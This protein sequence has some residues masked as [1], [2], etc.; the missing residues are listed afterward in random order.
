MAPG[1]DLRIGDA[2]RDVTTRQLRECFAQGRLT[3]DEFNDR[4]GKAL[5]ATTQPELDRLTRDLP[6]VMSSPAPLPHTA[7]YRGDPRYAYD[8]RRDHG[9]WQGQDAS[10][11][12]GT[13][14]RSRLGMGLAVLFALWLL[15]SVLTPLALFPFGGRIALLLLVFGVLRGIVRRLFGVR[16]RR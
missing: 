6:P 13:R 14:M 4:L 8:P 1:P 11:G 12:C 10:S 2:E 3:I 7:G 5:S 9:G 15:L 16:R